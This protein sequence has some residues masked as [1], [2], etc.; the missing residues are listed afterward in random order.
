[1]RFYLF[2]SGLGFLIVLCVGIAMYMQYHQESKAAYTKTLTN[3]ARLIEKQYPE[4]HDPGLLKQRAGTD[5]FWEKSRG[6]AD[7]KN[8]FGLAYIYYLERTASG[9]IFLMSSGIQRDENPMWLGGPVWRDHTPIPGFIT[10]AYETKKITYS[11]AFTKNE[12]GEM[13]SVG[14]PIITDGKVVGILGVDYDIS[15]ISDLRRDVKSTLVVS[16]ILAVAAV[17][18]QALLGYKFVFISLQNQK[19][20]ELTCAMMDATPLA[21]TLR[22]K[23]NNILECNLEAL[24]MF[25]VSHRSDFINK[26]QEFIPPFQ[27][28]GAS[29][30]EI[31]KRLHQE[32]F[33][34]GHLRFEWMYRTATGEALPVETT[35]VR[36]LWQDDYC[37]AV[38]SR[39]LRAIKANEDKMRMAENRVHAML[40]ATPLACVFLDAN[41][42]A[43]D[44]NAE[45]PRLFEVAS[46]EKFLELYY[47]WMPEYQPDGLHSL[48]EKRKRI[49]ETFNTGYNRSEWMHQ[50]AAGEALPAEVTLVRVEWNGIYCIATYIRDLREIKANERKMQEAGKHTLELEIRTQAAQAA[51]EAKSK[52]LASMSHEIRTPMNAIIGMSDLM[53]TDNLDQEQ[54]SFFNDIRKMSKTLLQ[55]INDILDFSK[56]EAGKLDLAPV[57]FDLSALLDNIVSLHRFM[58]ES[59]SLEF[60]YHFDA[61]VKRIIYSDDVRIR[62]IVTNI[63]NNAIKYTPQGYVEFRVGRVMENGQEYTA[64]IVED[65]GIGIRQEDFSRLFSEFEQI[66]SHRNRGIMGTGLGLSITRRLVEMMHGR[67]DVQSEYGKGSTFTVL[68]PLAECDGP[69]IKLLEC[70]PPVVVSDG[71]ASALVVD[72][73]PLNLKVASAYLAK[74][75]IRVDTAES[76]GEALQKVSQKHYQLIF[77]D[78]M[79]PEMD[80]LEA[81]ARIR[82][83][84]DEWCHTVPI[85]AFSANAIVGAHELFLQS[86]LNDFLAKPIDAGVFNSILAKW[87]PSDM[88]R[89]ESDDQ[90]G[91]PMSAAVER[92]SPDP[93]AEP[94]A[95][96]RNGPLL[97]NT[98]GLS[99]AANSEILYRQLMD[100]F[101]TTH[102]ADHLKIKAA[103]EAENYPLAH[104]LA[105]TLKSSSAQIGAKRLSIAALAVEKAL[106]EQQT[107]SALKYL[108]DLEAESDALIK[109]LMLIAPV[110]APQPRDAGSLDKAKALS[111][112]DKLEPLLNASNSASFT[113]LDE[114]QATFAPVGA[115]CEALTAHI[116]DFEFAGA[117]KI[118]V[119]IRQK[120]SA[121]QCAV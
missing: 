105:H 120:I 86:G 22:D 26:F 58:A 101:K 24:R 82:A 59:K 75:N 4:M 15:F 17:V 1:M 119:A 19:N 95:G 79:M 104:R 113:L 18:V 41:G 20:H 91:L 7:I 90:T 66:D 85:I 114:A 45:A 67:I 81:T 106:H 40:D 23:Q 42:K 93:D 70:S 98:A 43:I 52:F 69:Q 35:Y 92:V 94:G 64:F 10:A 99:N 5:W 87:L 31:A 78:H 11:P 16:L 34:T 73:N 108:E 57:R 44:C 21:C 100:D 27:P 121:D 83:L 33:E 8:T 115:E 97:D 65:T 74:A 84:E 107:A 80:G 28:D 111:L 13:A 89:C 68:L 55:I 72:D 62:Q 102:S 60:R 38:Y 25:G 49:A 30:M 47:D 56:I 51:S 63:L 2:F 71:R 29:S 112:I 14:L 46:K 53:R 6:L 37:I 76:G 77:M 48:T 61:E 103:L 50:T 32:A 88:I 12:W 3:V 96:E 116:K 39:D 36:M 109:E 117:A 110:E 54:V 118:L 9:Y